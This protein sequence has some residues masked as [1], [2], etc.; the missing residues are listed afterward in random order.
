MASATVTEKMP[1]NL[2]QRLYSKQKRNRLLAGEKRFNALIDQIDFGNTSL[3][4]KLQILNGR[5]SL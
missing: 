2:F 5:T 3:V 4:H 1:V